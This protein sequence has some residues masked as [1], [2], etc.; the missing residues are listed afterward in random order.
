M[1]PKISSQSFII[2]NNKEIPLSQDFAGFRFYYNNMTK[3]EYQQLINILLNN[4]HSTIKMVK[5][6]III[7]LI[8]ILFNQRVFLE[9]FIWIDFTLVSYKTLTHE[10]DIGN[11]IY[12]TIFIN[13]YGYGCL[14]MENAKT[15]IPN[16]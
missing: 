9:G 7:P 14:D 5:T 3:E 15:K 12:S 10:A 6:I 11:L 13:M 16:N 1:D 8:Q 2:N 4:L